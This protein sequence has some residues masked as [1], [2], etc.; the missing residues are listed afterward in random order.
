[1]AKKPY[2]A[3]KRG[4]GR[5]VQLP[6]YLQVSE[7]W[8]SLK[9]G[10]RALYVELKRRYNG[11]NNG[12]I[13]L[14]HRDAATAVN[15]GRD[16]VSGYF[17][18]LTTHGFIAVTRGHCLGPEGIGQSV[19]YRLTELPYEGAP[20]TKEFMKWKPSK[21]QN[22]RRKIQHPMAGKSDTPC[23]KIQ[24]TPIQMSENPTA[25]GPNDPNTVSE[26]PAIY[27]S[28]H[29]PLSFSDAAQR[30]KDGLGLC[31]KAT[32]IHPYALS[33]WLGADRRKGKVPDFLNDAA[34]RCAEKIR[35]H[36]FCPCGSM[37]SEMPRLT[38]RHC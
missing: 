8:A 14:S 16:T 18:D 28:N 32:A 5:H 33:A 35:L 9:N 13:F 2:K 37:R 4:A 15:V 21:K 31:E 3:H 38:Q 7:A 25:F 12:R 17:G 29:I 1:M 10:P 36:G 34:R 6:E 20:A 24:H 11:G 22:P 23:R 19:H 30:L 27:T 26:N